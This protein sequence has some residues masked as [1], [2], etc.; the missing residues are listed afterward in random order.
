[1][2]PFFVFGPLSTFINAVPAKDEQA[3]VRLLSVIFN[4]FQKPILNFGCFHQPAGL[5]SLPISRRSN[6]PPHNFPVDRVRKKRMS[7]GVENLRCQREGD[8]ASIIM[9]D[10]M[11]KRRRR[12][13]KTITRY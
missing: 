7:V 3:G 1:M 12:G 13:M 2:M 4:L 5:S 10:I 9:T 11:H 8:S 6:H